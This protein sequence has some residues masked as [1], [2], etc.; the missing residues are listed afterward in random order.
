VDGPS[1][2]ALSW[3]ESAVKQHVVGSRGLRE[4][5]APWL[6]RFGDGTAAVLRSG[7]A[8]DTEVAA[9]RLA[10]ARGI[11]APRLIAVGDGVMLISVVAGS[12]RIPLRTTPERLASLGAAAA[13]LHAVELAPTK[14]LPLRSRPIEGV[15]F[16]EWRDRDGTTPLLREAADAVARL[17]V[18][19]SGPVF[20]HGDLWQ[21]N[22]MWLADE[23]VAVIDWDAAGAGH[24][25]IDV[26]SMRCDAALLF[27][28]G[29]ADVVSTGWRERAGRPPED[30]AYWDVVAAVNTPPDLADWESVI[31][32]QGRTDL[33][34]ATLTTRRDDF[35]RAALARLAAT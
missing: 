1:D 8:F 35:L 11:P 29:A 30:V 3:A 19:L 26:G 31:Q 13:E 5:G 4:G 33:D 25:G 12:S 16:A 32:D 27:G 9:L 23:L 6:L 24:P 10:D 28:D 22:T 7:F 34:G 2:E 18:P 15:D 17:P 21:G 14:D 20:V